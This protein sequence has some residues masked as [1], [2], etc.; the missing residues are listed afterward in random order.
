MLTWKNP[1]RDALLGLMLLLAAATPIVTTAVD[2]GQTLPI[3]VGLGL[4]VPAG[5]NIQMPAGE[6]SRQ[7]AAT[8]HREPFRKADRSLHSQST[9]KPEARLSQMIVP[10]RT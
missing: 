4:I 7:C 5:E 6:S 8:R 3:K 10:L 9:P 2:N 1:A